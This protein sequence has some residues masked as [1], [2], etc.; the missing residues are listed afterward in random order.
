MGWPVSR[1]GDQGGGTSQIWWV[2]AGGSAQGDAACVGYNGVEDLFDAVVELD[3]GHGGAGG[4]LN[5]HRH[6]I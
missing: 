6:R 2:G 4:Q 1:S 3:G 5:R